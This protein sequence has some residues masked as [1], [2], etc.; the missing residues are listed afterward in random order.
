MGIL[1]P[2]YYKSVFFFFFQ[3]SVFDLCNHDM[4]EFKDG[5]GSKWKL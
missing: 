5:L 3:N 1:S 2:H 4:L